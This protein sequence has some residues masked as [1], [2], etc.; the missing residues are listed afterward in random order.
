MAPTAADLADAASVA[1]PRIISVD[2]HVVEPPDLWTSRLPATRKDEAPKVVR[3]KTKF[4]FS[5]AGL[6]IEKDIDDGEWC[7]FWEYADLSTPFPK[8]GAW[9]GLDSIEWTP[10]KYFDNKVICELI[11]SSK[12]PGIV[13]LLDEACLLAHWCVVCWWLL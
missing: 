2:D 3:R 11:E 1:I 12:P 13:A 9:I 6:K 5:T 10:V 7:D 4:E 8:T